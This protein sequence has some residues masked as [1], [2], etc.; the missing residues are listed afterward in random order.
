MCVAPGPRAPD[1]LWSFLMPVFEEL[2]VLETEGLRVHAKDGY[3]SWN[4]IISD[5][6][7][8]FRRQ[9]TLIT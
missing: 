7:D 2:K 1:D 4:T 5:S 8:T 9:I 3:A 6:L